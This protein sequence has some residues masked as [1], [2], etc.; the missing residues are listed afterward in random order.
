MK[1]Q[2]KYIKGILFALAA[3]IV[4]GI[5]IF[6]SKI[7]ASSIDPLIMATVRNSI[8]GLFFFILVLFGTRKMQMN[9][10]T[11][12]EWAILI[13]IGT[14][15]GSIPFYLFFSGIKLIGAQQANFIHKTLFVW[16][17][18]LSTVVFKEKINIGYILAGFLVLIGTVVV[19]PI[20]P[21]LG[22]GEQLVLSATLLWSV[23]A[24]LAKKILP[25]VK[26]EVVGLFRMGLGGAVLFITTF[27]TGKTT[28]LFQ[29]TS[30]QFVTL[31]VGAGILFFY[32]FLWYKSLRIAPAGLVSIILTFSLVVGNFLNGAFAGVSLTQNDIY[33]TICV[34]GGVTAIMVVR[35]LGELKHQGI[36]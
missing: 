5:A 3:S 22:M 18:L 11:K 24:I 32:V 2:N 14:I 21:I 15:G 8:A 29:L 17:F 20:K 31:F 6:Y 9:S 12:R 33:A 30:S 16:V 23:E 36:K 34:A 19:S 1:D 4:S 25:Q 35:L 10:L 27:L 28:L 13:L 26:E 7:S